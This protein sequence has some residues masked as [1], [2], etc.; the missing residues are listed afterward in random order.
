MRLTNSLSDLHSHHHRNRRPESD[1]PQ[2]QSHLHSSHFDPPTFSHDDFFDQMLSTIPPSWELPPSGALSDDAPPPPP[3][4][5]PD[6]AAFQFDESSSANNLASKLSGYQISETTAKMAMTMLQQQLLMSRAMV[7]AADSGL[8]PM[9]GANLE[10]SSSF[11]CPNPVLK[12]ILSNSIAN[13]H[14]IRK[15]RFRIGTELYPI[16]EMKLRNLADW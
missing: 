4:P 3:Q 5:N 7:T 9:P 2:L 12:L 14:S 16:P 13:N 1:A 15:I 10:D 6:N 8:L 11:K